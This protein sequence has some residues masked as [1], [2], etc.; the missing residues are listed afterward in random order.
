MFYTIADIP[1]SPLTLI[2][3]MGRGSQ[4]FFER[5]GS[6]LGVLACGAASAEILSFLA[7]SCSG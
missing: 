3:F 4:L 7:E 2:N 5:P 6:F 1:P